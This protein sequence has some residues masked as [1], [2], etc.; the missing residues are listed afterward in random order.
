MV[1]NDNWEACTVECVCN[2]VCK[3]RCFASA[4]GLLSGRN[5]IL[6]AC[7]QCHDIA[8]GRFRVD[9]VSVKAVACRERLR[10]AVMNAVHWCSYAL[11]G[12]GRHCS[13]GCVPSCANKCSKVPG[14]KKWVVN[15]SALVQSKLGWACAG[16]LLA[17]H[18]CTTVANNDGE[19]VYQHVCK[20][21]GPLE[22]LLRTDAAANL[23]TTPYL[24][25][26]AYFKLYA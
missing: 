17:C 4:G 26:S 18:F 8:L 13:V 25:N 24:R 5:R 14:G 22:L 20:M 7:K 1:G 16:S 6:R 3:P 10:R 9:S 23:D 12:S 2:K 19:N 21:Q 15:V 11:S